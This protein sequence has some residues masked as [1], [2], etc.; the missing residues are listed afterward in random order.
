MDGFVVIGTELETKSFDKQ[1]ER[2]ESQLEEIDHMLSKPKDFN[3]TETDIAD[4]NVKAEKLKNTLIGLKKQQLK[5][6]E[7]NFF[8]NA[9]NSISA[10]IK[11]TL[12]WGVALFGIRSA[13]SFISRSM[14]T[15][16]QYNEQI[17][18]DL[19][20][21]RFAM[22][23]ALEPAIEAII[24]L[25]YKLLGIINSISIA[26]F[27]VN[28]FANSSAGRFK[29]MSKSAAE[30]KKSL[31]GF[32]EM[33]IVQDNSSAGGGGIS[34]PS[35]DLS[36]LND[37]EAGEKFKSF[38]EEIIQFWENDWFDAFSSIDGEWGMFMQ[39]VGFTSKGI[40]DII[41][42][43]I[44][45]LVGLWDMLVGLFTGDTEKLKEGWDKFV[46]GIK[47]VLVGLVE[48][49]IGLI[50]MLVGTI[51]GLIV[52]LGKLLWAGIEGFINILIDW[53]HKGLDFIVGVLASIGEF[54]YKYVIDPITK[55]FGGLWDGIVEGS[56]KAWNGIKNAFGSMVSFFSNI[57][58][59]IF[60]F[61]KD[62]GS[63]AGQA[64]SSSFKTIVNA[65][66][67]TIESVLNS[68]IKAI[69]SLISVINKVPGINL[70]KLSTFSL[71]RLAKGGI[72]NMP[73]QGVSLGSAIAG[74]RGREAV[75]PLTDSQ[76]MEWLGREIGKN[77]A[78]NATIVN[79]MNGRVISRE[80]QKIQNEESF[81][82]NR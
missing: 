12:K 5:I 62:I 79:S 82:F 42:G 61:F 77:I 3:L 46:K 2:I 24:Q 29:S 17:G 35:V 39:G 64:I 49:I 44:D 28:L 78:I 68:P 54:L 57:K 34:A 51:W 55:F 75:L 47:E 13:Y 53:L 67:K 9:S 37:T 26:L 50:E 56:K 19:S 30:M 52:D 31:A 1:I 27:N 33:N 70:G 6:N 58:D 41:K 20:Y 76:Q 10:L 21:I 36:Q 48:G 74:E 4:L 7:N 60:S 38:W 66:L 14:S 63:K 73:G 69:N 43:V 81:G 40:Y 71:P 18:T 22:A 80:L 25:A 15:L 32:D 8:E 11:K 45:M 72:V 23:S 59:K 65:V 16:S